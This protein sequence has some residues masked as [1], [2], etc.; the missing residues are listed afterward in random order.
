M[1]YFK[2]E[3]VGDAALVFGGGLA[4]LSAGYALTRNGRKAVVFE[5]DSA[6]GGLSK[7]IEM[8][9]FRFDIG[10]HRFHTKDRNVEELV[11]G[12]MGNEL[13]TVSRKSKIFMRDR[14]FDYPL[15]P[16]NAMFGLGVGT[17]LRILFDYGW[18]R[19]KGK[20]DNGRHVSLED[21]VVGNF[22][23]T[24]FNIYFKE[25]SEK[26]WGLE[27]DRI[28]QGWVARRIDGLSLG[29]AVKNAFFK[30]SGRGIPTLADNFLYPE[31]G[32]GRISERLKEEICSSN[33]LFTETGVVGLHHDGKRIKGVEVRNC[34][35]SYRIEGEGYISTIPLNNV[36]FMLQPEPPEEVL[37]AA[38]SLGFRDLVI[39]AV[40]VNRR[41]VTDQT[42]VYIPEKKY[43]F[44]RL[45]EPKCWSPKMAPRDKTLVVVEYFCFRGD[46]IWNLADGELSETT[47]SGL[48]ELEFIRREE[49]LDTMVLRVPR[50]YPLF[51][52]GYEKHCET[53]YKYLKRF[54]NLFIA[55][56]SGMFQYQNMDHAIASG[57]EAA[58]NLMRGK[59]I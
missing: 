33:R 41:S 31:L 56:R 8:G 43:P 35:N 32:I 37:R 26:V 45:H 38:R 53:I 21:W 20:A 44:G 55:G 13:A 18:E 5:A 23:R 3:D 47:V 49:A 24:M 16:T 2:I 9:D 39:V 50:A 30:F 46:G 57:M 40:S 58:E 6:V 10:G 25:Y 54:D 51:E 52:V 34:D 48:E 1:G 59:D 22:G 17:V 11:K 27:C 36:V 15:R 28:S 4:G 7:T 19:L 29:K 14:F 42:W 12:L